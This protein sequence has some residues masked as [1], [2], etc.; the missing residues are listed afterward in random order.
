MGPFRLHAL[1]FCV[2][3]LGAT[4]C[5]PARRGLS[6]HAR[7]PTPISAAGSGKRSGG[8]MAAGTPLRLACNQRTSKLGRAPVCVRSRGEG[9]GGRSPKAD[10]R[11][12]PEES[13]EATGMKM[14]SFSPFPTC[15]GSVA[16]KVTFLPSF[17]PQHEKCLSLLH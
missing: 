13:K 11:R 9:G 7:P 15:F 1:M 6:T 14:S 10:R 4:V 12:E 2:A 16:P 5:D 17:L 8:R 3:V